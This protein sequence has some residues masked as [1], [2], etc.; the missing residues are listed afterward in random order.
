MNSYLKNS[1]VI[2]RTPP[3]EGGLFVLKENGDVHARLDGFVV[4]PID[5]VPD[6]D[7]FLR[8]VGINADPSTLSI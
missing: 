2:D 6:L 5:K 4:V 3:V 7:A 8:S 1:I